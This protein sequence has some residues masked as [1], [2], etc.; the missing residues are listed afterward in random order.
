MPR[1]DILGFSRPLVLTIE[2]WKR[3]FDVTAAPLI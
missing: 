3:L 2:K 1:G